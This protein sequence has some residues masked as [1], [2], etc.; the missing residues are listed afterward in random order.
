V[1]RVGRVDTGLAR[2]TTV[3]ATRSRDRLAAAAPLVLAV[4]IAA[5]LAWIY[6]T[7]NG[8]NFVD[9]HTYLGGAATVDVGGGLYDYVYA[10]QTPDFALPFVYPPFAAVVFYPLQLLPFGVLGFAWTLATIAA[11]YGVVCV[12]LR[13]SP[14]SGWAHRLRGECPQGRRGHR[15]AM[16]W[17]AVG[18]WIEPVRSTLDYGQLNVLLVL[19]VLCAVYST[20]W[21]WSGILVGLAAGIKLTPAIS[22]VYFVG[23]RRWSTALCAAAVFAATVVVSAM[24]LGTDQV[25]YFFTHKIGAA[26]QTF[27]IATATNQSWYGGITRILGRD[28]GFGWPVV[29]CVVATT[30]LAVLAWRALDPRD[31][32]GR[33]LVVML[34]GLLVSPISWTHHWVWLLPMT[35]WLVGG[36]NGERASAKVFGWGWLVLTLIGPTWLLGFAQRDLWQASRPW[37]LAWAG[38]VYIVATLA[39]LAWIA[40]SRRRAG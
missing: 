28:A 37:Y 22:G 24:V 38:L 23:T 35:M 14:A 2:R 9:L 13:L 26:G 20:R 21:W 16:W 15:E 3:I 18:I 33:I 10:E 31:R 27:P 8:A 12:T 17:T 34:F 5:R 32:L 39:T 19:A 29:L 40:A 1:V 7:P 4:S 25:A 6:L 11:L 30:V 36:A